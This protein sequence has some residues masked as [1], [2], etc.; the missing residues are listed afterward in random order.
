MADEGLRLQVYDD[1]TGRPIVA[2]SHVIG[3]P[4]IG[5]G[6]MLSVPGGITEAEADSLLAARIAAARADAARLGVFKELNPARQDVIVE[7]IYQMGFSRVLQFTHMLAH[8]RSHEYSEAAA[9][10]L[11]SA[12]ARQTPARARELANV[13]ETGQA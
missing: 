12:W 3:N 8:L 9:E 7:M 4:T 5:Y 2:G 1:A 10:M 11:N 13:M 6:C